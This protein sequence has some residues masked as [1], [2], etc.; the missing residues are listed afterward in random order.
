MKEQLN[1]FDKCRIAIEKGYTCNPETGK[2]FGIMGKEIINKKDGYIDIS[3]IYN[4]KKH[5]LKA[6]QFIYFCVN[7]E[8]DLSLDIDHI[9]N[10]RDSNQ[11]SNLRLTTRSE[12]LQNTKAK[13]YTWNKSRNEW[14]A[15]IQINNK[16]IYL[17]WYKLEEDARDAYLKAKKIYHTH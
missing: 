4:K 3:F 10:L 5:H 17:G 2:V 8:Y 16:K 9:N 7:G 14:Q 13:G 1:R 15:Q 12:N 6:H 11:I